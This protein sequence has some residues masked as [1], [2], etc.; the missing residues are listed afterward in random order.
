MKKI[1]TTV[2]VAALGLGCASISTDALAR[3]GGDGAAHMAGGSAP[4]GGGAAQNQLAFLATHE[5]DTT[6]P[7]PLRCHFGSGTNIRGATPRSHSKA[8]HPHTTRRR[9]SGAYPSP[10]P[11][12]AGYTNP[13]AP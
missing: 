5:C 6:P 7:V 10:A 1:T 13:I 12:T 11:S 2:L 8:A 4:F 3:G 9:A